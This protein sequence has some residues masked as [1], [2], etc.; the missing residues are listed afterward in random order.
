MYD[1]I[2]GLLPGG[3][4]ARELVTPDLSLNLNVRQVPPREHPVNITLDC[5]A[6]TE[7]FEYVA[8]CLRD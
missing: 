4:V 1:G 2:Q 6:L 5:S 3:L 7:T 8:V